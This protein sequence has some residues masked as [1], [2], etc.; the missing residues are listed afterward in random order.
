MLDVREIID[1]LCF[2]LRVFFFLLAFPFVFIPWSIVMVAANV[3][4]A[5][6]IHVFELC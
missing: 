1:D 5:F 3:H 2:V 4:I 6:Q